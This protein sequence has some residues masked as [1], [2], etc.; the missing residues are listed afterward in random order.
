[1][2]DTKSTN[3]ESVC[4]TALF[5]SG[6]E[7]LKAAQIELTNAQNNMESIRQQIRN[8]GDVEPDSLLCLCDKED[9]YIL[10]NIMNYLAVNDLGRCELV[11]STLNEQAK[12]TIDNKLDGVHIT[13]YTGKEAV[14]KDVTFVG[15]HPSVVEISKEAFKDCSKLRHVVLNEGLVSI[16]K[17]AFYNCTSLTSIKFPS[18]LME[19]ADSAFKGN[20]NLEEV[21]LNNGL[22]KI[23][24]RVFESCTSLESII[25]PPNLIDLGY[26]VFASCTSLTDVVFNENAERRMIGRLEVPLS[27][28]EQYQLQNP[29][30]DGLRSSDS[31][32]KEI[33]FHTGGLRSIE[34]GMFSDCK[35][36]ERI[37]LPSTIITIEESAFY[38]CFR[39]REVVLNKGLWRIDCQAFFRCISLESIT[40]PPAPAAEFY[41]I[42]SCS[43]RYC[44][45]LREVILSEGQTKI[46]D[47]SGYGR[48]SLEQIDSQI[49]WSV[50]DGAFAGCRSLE[51]FKFP[52]IS[53]R[54]ERIIQVGHTDIVT[55]VN[56][57]C[58][59]VVEWKSN[60]L[61]VSAAETTMIS[62]TV[63]SVNW[64]YIK[65][66]LNT[67]VNLLA[68][69]E[70]KESTVLFELA[71]WKAK[72]YQDGANPVDRA[73]SRTEVPWRVKDTILQFMFRGYGN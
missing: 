27:I 62:S 33:V 35:S 44:T 23:G 41:S 11:C 70:F 64:R 34:K 16:R 60:E 7:R 59:G 61:V 36:L 29:A 57:I 24:D 21:V 67:I 20:S 49:S 15:F 8:S 58:G 66:S 56:E 52:Y 45:H 38:E 4:T 17:D 5:A 32:L 63:G 6:M 68:F 47:G 73:A 22:Q 9:N 3:N 25:L 31:N 48:S 43:F 13:N 28:D 65:E 71:L 26:Y 2:M 55:K 19:I 50:D 14:P 69:Y 37:K 54:L 51:Y 40:L 53:V 18:T 72:I 12:K 42:E 30:Y 10:S 1:M 46:K 39:L